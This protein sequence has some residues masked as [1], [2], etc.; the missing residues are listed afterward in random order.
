MSEKLL[1]IEEVAERLNLAPRTIYR[2][3]KDGKL[4]AR[5][6]GKRWQVKEEDLIVF[7]DGIQP[8]K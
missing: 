6:I 7:I 3:I 8:N 4:T 2:Y 1:T 5:K